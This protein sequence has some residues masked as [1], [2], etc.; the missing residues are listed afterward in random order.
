VIDQ[1]RMSP[2]ID[3]AFSHWLS[4]LP[5]WRLSSAA[6]R[7]S[8]C[9]RCPSYMAALDLEGMMHEP[10]HALFCAVHAIIDDR[11]AEEDAAQFDSEFTSRILSGG[12][13]DARME[14]AP[15]FAAVHT[16][17]DDITLSRRRAALFDSAVA[18]LALRRPAM[19]AAVRDFVEPTVQRMA[20]ELIAEVCAP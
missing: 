16:V 9:V 10:V 11:F 17:A 6:P 1:E 12:V 8:S 7:R 2:D 5:S 20:D 4:R 18:V 19:L 15:M 3:I 14:S 13:E